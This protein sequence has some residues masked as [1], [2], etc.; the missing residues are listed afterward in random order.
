MT[1]R[2]TNQLAGLTCTVLELDAATHVNVVYSDVASG[3]VIKKSLKH[4]LGNGRE[5]VFN[6]YKCGSILSDIKVLLND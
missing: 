3:W 1:D 6:K 5:K 4:H 2:Q